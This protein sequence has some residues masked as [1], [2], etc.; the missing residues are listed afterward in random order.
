MSAAPLRSLATGPALPCGPGGALPLLGRRSAGLP[1][2]GGC[3][4]RAFDAEGVLRPAPGL[5]ELGLRPGAQLGDTGLQSLLLGRIPELVDG[6]LRLVQELLARALQVLT[7]LA[8]V[9]EQLVVPLL[10]GH[11]VLPFVALRHP[12]AFSGGERTPPEPRP[13]PA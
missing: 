12:G 6:P 1:R 13:I 2:P 3:R 10:F 8:H 5:L 9:L 11:L 4:F 7:R